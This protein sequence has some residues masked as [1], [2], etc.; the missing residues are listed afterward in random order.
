MSIAEKLRGS[1]KYEMGCSVDFISIALTGDRANCKG[2]CTYCRKE[3]VEKLADAIEAEQN[4]SKSTPLPDGIIW[5]TFEDGT[6]VK[7]GDAYVNADGNPAEVRFLCMKAEGFKVGRGQTKNRWQPWGEAVKRNKPDTQE[8]IESDATAPSG[9][10]CVKNGLVE[11]GEDVDEATLIERHIL[12][13]LER[14]RNLTGVAG[15]PF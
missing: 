10:Y 12:H 5:P 4:A 9:V 11:K 13:L 2:L 14:Q 3:W 15:W 6:P 7:F 1:L 8:A